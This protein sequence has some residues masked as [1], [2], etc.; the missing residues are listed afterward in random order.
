[1][2]NRLKK[3]IP[4]Q[5]FTFKQVVII[6]VITLFLGVFS[7]FFITHFAIRKNVLPGHRVIDRQLRDFIEVYHTLNTEYFQELDKNELISG[8]IKGMLETIDDPHTIYLD[9]DVTDNFNVRLQGSFNGVGLEI[10]RDREGRTVVLNPFEDG[11][12]YKAGIRTGDI[13]TRVDDQDISESPITET[14]AMIKGP[15]GTYVEI[16][17]NRNNEERSFKIQRETITIRSVTSEVMEIDNQKIGYININIF[18]SLT[19]D[20]FNE[21]LR[22]LRRENVDA[23]IID[24]RSNAGGYLNSVHDILSNFLTRDDVLYQIETSR[25]TTKRH[26]RGTNQVDLPVVV[27]VNERSASAAEI[28]AAALKESYGAYV[29]GVTTHGKGTV[30]QPRRLSTGGMFKF[31]TQNWLTPEGNRVEESGVPPTHEVRLNEN[32][33]REPTR[34]NDNQLQKAI[35]LLTK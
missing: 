26:G 21:E 32:F 9:S 28:L 14:S 12:A 24:V 27:L 34:D 3:L 19:T 5:D 35:E 17:V 8:A 10:V 30:Q 33:F 23:L 22:K 29:V 1:M 13:I 20:Q 16:T 7:G 18:S 4:N 2:K 15:V 31:T 25:R 11:P 6:T